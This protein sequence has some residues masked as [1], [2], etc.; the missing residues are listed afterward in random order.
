MIHLIP[1]LP[2]L[3]AV[4][5]TYPM[6]PL[7]CC[8]TAA[9]G[10]YP[11]AGGATVGCGCPTAQFIWDQQRIQSQLCGWAEIIDPSTPPVYYKTL[12]IAGSASQTINYTPTSQSGTTGAGSE[13]VYGQTVPAHTAYDLTQTVQDTYTNTFTGANSYANGLASEG[14]GCTESYAAVD[15]WTAVETTTVTG[16]IGS[17]SVDSSSEAP[18][19]SSPTGATA[20]VE[21]VSQDPPNVI[22]A[23]FAGGWTSSVSSESQTSY[24]VTYS[25]NGASGSVTAT[26]SDPVDEGSEISSS[27]TVEAKFMGGMMGGSGG[28]YDGTGYRADITGEGPNPGD[29]IDWIGPLWAD[30]SGRYVDWANAT[31]AILIL[32]LISGWSWKVTVRVYR[33]SY[34]LSADGSTQSFGTASQVGSDL[35]FTFTASDTWALI[36][37]SAPGGFNPNSPDPTTLSPSETVISSSITQGWIYGA[38]IIA[39]EPA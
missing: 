39:V 6:W 28:Y 10:T 16:T 7:I 19:S 4:G 24:T 8:P 3:Y 34:S 14:G 15:A 37:A 18:A 1:L 20:G 27:P 31:F 13:E 33:A 23:V 11:Y 38:Q 22:P 12:T 25:G 29:G 30:R 36:G 32:G 26:L 17:D 9:G 2:L 35:V 21:G 5:V